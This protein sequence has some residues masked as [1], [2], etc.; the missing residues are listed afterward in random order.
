[1]A[2][3]SLNSHNSAGQV[4]LEM[5]LEGAKSLIWCSK[6]GW[7]TVLCSWSIDSGREFQMD[8]AATKKARQASSVC[9]QGTTSVGASE[10]HRAESADFHHTVTHISYPS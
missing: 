2:P 9:M 1:M 6:I 8:E 7:Q 5:T 10:E 3:N 4:G